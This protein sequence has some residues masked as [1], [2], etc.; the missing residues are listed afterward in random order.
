M[1]T[2]LTS[3]KF[4]KKYLYKNPT[5][6]YHEFC[7]AW[8]YQKMIKL[9]N[10]NLPKQQLLEQA[11]TMWAGVKKNNVNKIKILLHVF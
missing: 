10:V 7:N 8:A 5:L 11:N 2:F 1:Q 4:E 6:L 3:P 9:L